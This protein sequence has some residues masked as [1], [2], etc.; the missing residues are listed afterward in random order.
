VLRPDGKLQEAI[1]NIEGVSTVRLE[2]NTFHIGC[3][4]DVTPV[5]A[6]LI[7][8]SGAG[9]FSLQK[10]EYGLDDIY[11]RYFVGGES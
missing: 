4:R 5:I 11:N 6:E 8:T 1:G 10:K 2:E 3:M 9:L 7:V